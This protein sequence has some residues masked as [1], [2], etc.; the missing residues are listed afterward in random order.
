MRNF[1]FL[2]VV[3]CFTSP[4]LARN[5]AWNSSDAARIHFDNQDRLK[6]AYESRRRQAEEMR[7]NIKISPIVRMN[8]KQERAC[9]GIQCHLVDTHKRLSQWVSSSKRLLI[10]QWDRFERKAKSAWAKAK[11]EILNFSSK[12]YVGDPPEAGGIFQVRIS[13]GS[14]PIVHFSTDQV[15]SDPDGTVETITWYYGDGTSQAFSADE[16]DDYALV[17]HTY[18]QPGHYSVALSLIDNDGNETIYEEYAEIP[19][20]Q[21]PIPTFSIDTNVGPAPLSITATVTGG[22][23]N[24]IAL[25][26]WDSGDGARVEGN[27][28]EIEYEYTT[29]GTYEIRLDLIDLFNSWSFATA[30]VFVGVTPPAWGSRP[31]P[32]FDSTNLIGR[33]PHYVAFD[34]SNSFDI[35][36]TVVEYEWDFG[37][38][39]SL[40]NFSTGA[41]TDHV[42][43]IPGTYVGRLLVRDAQ[44]GENEFYFEVFVEGEEPLAPQIVAFQEGN[45][46]TINFDG[47]QTSLR[48]VVT[49]D[50][51]QWDFGDGQTAV[52]AAPSHTYASDG[53]YTVTLNAS[54]VIGNR[55]QIQ[56][57]I[58]VTS[59]NDSPQAELDISTSH[60]ETSESVTFDASSSSDPGQS[61]SLDYRIDLGNGLQAETS[62]HVYTY[63]E[64]GFYKTEL[65]VT[66]TRGLSH[67][68]VRYI[69]VHEGSIPMADIRYAPKVGNIP[70]AVDFDASFSTS[71]NSNISEYIWRIDDQVLSRSAQM[72]QVIC[73]PGQYFVELVVMDENGNFAFDVAEIIAV[74]PGAIPPGNGAPSAVFTY[75]VDPVDS[76]KYEF[77]ASGSSD[78]N[79]DYKIYEWKVN[80]ELIG[81]AREVM[82]YRFPTSNIYQVSLTVYDQWGASDTFMQVIDLSSVAE[83]QLA[84]DYA[85]I[86]PIVG[87]T[88]QFG[89][90]YAVVP[91]STIV[92][93]DWDFGDSS[94]ASGV[95][96]THSYASAGTYTVE[97]TLTDSNNN[98]FTKTKEVDVAATLTN[99]NITVT[100]RDVDLLTEVKNSE[101]YRGTSFPETIHFSVRSTSDSNRFIEDATWDFGDGETGFGPDVE[102]TYTLPGTYTVSVTGYDA[103]GLSDTA[104]L[105]VVIPE[106]CKRAEGQTECLNFQGLSK[107]VLPFTEEA[108]VIKRTGNFSVDPRFFPKEWIY[109]K[110]L[111]GSDDTVDLSEV[112]TVSGDEVSIS[113]GKLVDKNIDFRRPYKLVI[114]TVDSG[115]D[116][117]FA[118]VPRVYFGAGRMR[119]TS[120]DP[121]V[122]LIA[123]NPSA[124]YQKFIDLGTGTEISLSNLPLG[125]TTVIA[126]RNGEIETVNIDL[127]PNELATVALDF[128]LMA[129]KR[130]LA[131][132]SESKVKKFSLTDAWKRR[133]L[134]AQSSKLASRT[135]GSWPA[136]AYGLCG[137]EP[138]FSTVKERSLSQNQESIWA[139]TSN[140]PLAQN[141]PQSI[142]ITVNRP[143][144]LSCAISSESLMYGYVRWKYKDGPQRCWEDPK[145]HWYWRW[146]LENLT[147]EDDIVTIRYEVQD[148]WTNE[149]FKNVIVT[150]ASSMRQAMGRELTDITQRIGIAPEENQEWA[151][152]QDFDLY[153]PP[154]FKR[155]K[156]SFELS[157]SNNPIENDFYF[158]SC[159]VV[160]TID[161]Q[162]KAIELRPVAYNHPTDRS[163]RNAQFSLQNRY[164][165]FPVHFDSRV[166]SAV[167]VDPDATK[168]KYELVIRYYNQSTITWQGVDVEFEYNGATHVESYSFAGTPVIDEEQGIYKNTFTIDTS[169]LANTFNW[170]P[171]EDRLQLTITPQ[172]EDANESP[173]AGLPMTESFV[174]LFDVQTIESNQSLSICSNGYFGAQYTT[175]AQTGLVSSLKAMADQSLGIRCGNMSLP[176]GGP[177]DVAGFTQNAYRHGLAAN[178]RT[179]NESAPDQDSYDGSGASLRKSDIDTYILFS[180]AAL[181]ISQIPDEYDG[182]M[183]PTDKKKILDFCKPAGQTPKYPCDEST[184]FSDI[185]HDMVLQICQ[186]YSD[187]G[188]EIDG[189][190]SGY[191]PEVIRF[192]KWVKRNTEDLSGVKNLMIQPSLNSGL[193]FDLNRYQEDQK[194]AIVY[195]V[196]PDGKPIWDVSVSGTELTNKRVMTCH[197]NEQG[198]EQ[199]KP[200]FIKDNYYVDSM[201]LL[202]GWRL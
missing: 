158:V 6:K 89:A 64:P 202:N 88:I 15:V 118:E 172:G 101:T 1:I 146:Y 8:Y 129:K 71:Q 199:L 19:N 125:P 25:Y 61:L 150:S 47:D 166:T 200:S 162:P 53:M 121:E 122:R 123:K 106:D 14:R 31:S 28:P 174:A 3:F 33:A 34:A 58:T 38:Y 171:G 78:P 16:L 184:Q 21:V 44:G 154:H 76:Y 17:S 197:E 139:F 100:A 70:L 80:G 11:K 107:N 153:I 104:S 40:D 155:P 96:V 57:E 68:V 182:S 188:A 159:D 140:D 7:R 187:T 111:D 82:S 195:G 108:W 29:P 56:K 198:C 156:I 39:S 41:N 148:E 115:N 128:N 160:S 75:G 2:F 170:V 180:D 151:Y 46:R 50:M 181:A 92:S 124:Q 119:I 168:A 201:E 93:Y 72:Q 134:W 173:V 94:V 191:L 65:L 167:G 26:A 149:S 90:E 120:A 49:A 87:Q 95:S 12:K 27:I 13:S 52:G 97:L 126:E 163:S 112:A 196:W 20:N 77:D 192:S 45:S 24:G 193:H 79:G 190:P 5:G 147:Y 83:Q 130:R 74:D 69:S 86:K 113:K 144:R 136:W 10:Q 145:A 60:V 4:S 161:S 9:S 105:T 138:P 98:T 141:N 132:V 35:D 59:S 109:L 99:P 194:R 91:G 183:N 175:F 142:P 102:Y 48:S 30:E 43:K 133:E 131:S 157:S 66:N 178:V 169:V 55:I 42:Y 37:D 22:D 143:V 18:P 135:D 73:D 137:E 185:N 63:L 179:F 127:K 114:S 51:Y 23:S 54:D 152:R 165:Y 186:W 103:N 176:F 32:V 85:P 62:P 84:F 36:G 117:I 81:G 177:M 110:A 116:S 164:K 67:R 189:C